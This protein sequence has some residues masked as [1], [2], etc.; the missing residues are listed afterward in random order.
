MKPLSL[1]SGLVL[2]AAAFVGVASGANP[3]PPQPVHAYPGFAPSNGNSASVIGPYFTFGD[4]ADTNLSPCNTLGPD[5]RWDGDYDV[6]LDSAFFGYGAWA[7]DPDCDYQL[8]AHGPNVSVQDVVFGN[9]ISFIVA[10]NDQNGPI[11]FPLVD[12]NGN[13]IRY[14]CETDG[15]ISPCPPGGCDFNDPM[16]D[17]DDCAGPV[18]LGTGQTCGYGGGDG[19]YWVLFVPASNV[20]VAGTIVAF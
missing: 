2:C 6:G 16:Q 19:G 5:P 18:Y 10:E 15:V 9:R 13:V 8:H 12:Q 11:K 14:F 17:H 20:P 4:V 1:A 3:C 7:E